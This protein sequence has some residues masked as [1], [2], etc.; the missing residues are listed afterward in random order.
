[1]SFERVAIDEL[2]LNLNPLQTGGRA[3]AAA[4]KAAA[5]FSDGYS[6]CDR[7]AGV[8]HDIEKPDIKCFAVELAE[9]VG[10]DRAAVTMG[11]REGK[12]AIFHTL[13]EPGRGAVLDANAHYSTYVAAQ[14]AGL[15]VFKSTNTGDPDFRVTPDSFAETLEY[16][17]SKT[18]KPAAAALLTHVD[19]DY[20]NLNDAAEFSK[21]CKD[22]GVPLI[23]NC[24]YSAGRMPVDGRALGVDFMVGSGHKSFAASGPVGFMGAN[25]EWTERLFRTSLTHPNKNIELL[26]CTARGANV[27]SF[28]AALP[29]VKERVKRWDAEVAKAVRFVEAMES[30]GEIR[31]V[32]EKPKR[33][34]LIRFETP[35][36]HRI[37]ENSR[38]RGYFLHSALAD[39]GI[40]GLKPGQTRWFKMSTFGFTDEQIDYLIEAFK[41][42]ARM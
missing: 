4:R 8:L 27:V 7:C 26:G 2:A 25:G 1:M 6:V 31:Q 42:I 16:C 19:G 38:K 18:G 13:S 22:A 23:L 29:G 30:L 9:F 33:H 36:F 14:R 40:T 28:M 20:G 41:E 10:M 39:R 15:E 32:G 3:S 21:I 5:R 17:K 24:A 35:L 34:D 37:A 12:F 11:A